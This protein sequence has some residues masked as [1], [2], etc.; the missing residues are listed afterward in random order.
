MSCSLL[1]LWLCSFS[2]LSYGNVIYDI[3]CLYSLGSLSCR[4]VV[5]DIATVCLTTYTIVGISDG[6]TLP[7]IIFCGLKFV[8]SYSFFILEPKAPPSSTLF[9]LLK[10]L[11]RESIAAFF[12]FTSV[13]YISSLVVLTLASGFCGLSFWCTNK[14]WKI[15]ANT[16]AN[17]HIYFLSPLLSLTYLYHLSNSLH[18]LLNIICAQSTCYPFSVL[19]N[20]ITFL[21]LKYCSFSFW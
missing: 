16:K 10:T 20:V 8:L 19:T 17:W 1:T 21:F 14:Y 9:F 11:F 15:F 13:V 7:L 2:Y 12:M 5:Y 6:S 3:S 18:R 4:N